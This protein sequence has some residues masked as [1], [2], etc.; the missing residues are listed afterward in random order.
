MVNENEIRQVIKQVLSE[1]NNTVITDS[2][3]ESGSFATVGEA[4]AA[5]KV[6]Q[7]EYAK[8]SIADRAKLISEI[9]RQLLPDSEE[10]GR[11]A[12]EESGM[13]RAEDKKVKVE[14]ALTKTPGTEDL[15]T[16]ALTGDNG[17][18]MYEH[19]PYGV[20]GAILP[21]TNPV[22][23]IINNGIGMLAGGNAVY[24]SVHPGAH[25]VSL[26]LI[27]RI[28]KIIKE[29]L[30]ID[31]L[32]VTVADAYPEAV[33]E[34]MHNDDIAML[35]ITGGPGI[36]K[37]GLSSGKKTIGA[38]AGNPPVLVD[39][40]ADIQRAGKEIF[41]G[42]SFDNAILCTAEKAVVAVESIE[43]E[44]VQE[45]ENAGALLISNKDDI[46]KIV[47]VTIK[48][49]RPNKKFTGKNASVI[50]D[51]AG[52]AYTGDPKLII[53]R[54]PKEHPLV[55]KEMLMPI[56]PIVKVKDFDEGLS[57][58]LEVEQGFHHTSMMHTTNIQRMDKM[59]KAMETS[60]FVINASSFSGIGIDGEGPTTFTIATP[61]GEGT[62]TAKDFTRVRRV[63]SVDGICIKTK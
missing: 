56:L 13:G 62:T 52:I 1:Y 29:T 53:M 33:D 61:T 31:N 36:V 15:T 18:T 34:L 42:G 8:R 21:S 43:E 9:R 20:I 14:V 3:R 45:L 6:A 27:K 46:Q 58:S 16:T 55:M 30:N 7:R 25:N 11:E 47:D 60:I 22:A 37:M 35:A 4:V 57:V 17:M 44:L 5:A 54:A 12:A 63:V 51:A 41:K 38:G 19:S 10:L 26:K 40:T 50:L 23:T 48:D 32:F 24:F 39:E 28:N 2:N 59:A 49:N